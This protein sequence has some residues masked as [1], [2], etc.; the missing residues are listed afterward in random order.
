MS[1]DSSQLTARA[2]R[3]DTERAVIDIGSNTVRLVI[4]GDPQRSPTVL[5]NEKVVAQLGQDLEATGLIPDLSIEIALLAL[6]R[7]ALILEDRGIREIDVVATAAA[8]DAGNGPEFV[9]RIR[10][11]G[12]KPRLLSG[13]QEA[14][15]AAAGVAGAFPKASGL[16]ADLGG[17]SLEL[18]TL[19]EGVAGQGTTLPLG[20]LRLAAL[21]ARGSEFFAQKV[22]ELLQ[23][24]EWAKGAADDLYLVGGTLRCLAAYVIRQ[25]NYPL[26]DPHGF[27]LSAKRA[28]TIAQTVA[29]MSPDELG[30]I[31]GITSNRAITLP[32]AAALLRTMLETY[33]PKRVVFSSW[34]LREGLLFDKLEPL[35]Q[36]QDPLLAGVSHFVRERGVDPAVATHVAGWC[37][38]VL[39]ERDLADSRWQMAA[40]MLALAAARVEPNW[41]ARHALD[42]A[43]Y[44]RWIALDAEARGQIAAAQLASC[45]ITQ[46]PEEIKRI[47]SKD[48]IKLAVTWGLAIRLCRRMTAGTRLSLLTSKLRLAGDQLQL[49]LDTTRKDLNGVG[50]EKDMRNLAS[51]L[52]VEPNIATGELT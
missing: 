16:V 23:A 45:G 22:A 25:D 28:D 47:A 42:W 4:Y 49:T 36:E 51:W 41:R 19:T 5:L 31:E 17:G 32:D 9:E 39:P 21:H 35:A 46:M 14:R 27:V 30:K 50:V 7:Y 26:T 52:G 12:L 24:Q 2:R 34:G 29:Q 6:R 3:N 13:E 37:S 48:A 43:M 11:M 33:Q 18:I 40:T 38:G 1:Q 20:T 44:K 10:A 8:R 15:A